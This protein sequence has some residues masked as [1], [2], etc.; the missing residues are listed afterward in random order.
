MYVYIL[1]VLCGGPVGGSVL[2]K[3]WET[4]DFFNAVSF[5]AVGFVLE[6]VSYGPD[7][8]GCRSARRTLLNDGCLYQFN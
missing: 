8:I 1:V 4:F 6:L 3:Y 7:V 2:G 5:S